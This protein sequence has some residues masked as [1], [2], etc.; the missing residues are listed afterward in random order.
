MSK[1]CPKIVFEKLEK[2]LGKSAK[3]FKKLNYY[4]NEISDDA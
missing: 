3:F 4:P 2:F 1:E